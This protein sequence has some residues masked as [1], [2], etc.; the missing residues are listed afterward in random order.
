M[1]LEDPGETQPRKTRSGCLLT[2]LTFTE[3]PGGKIPVSTWSYAASFKTTATQRTVI[4]PMPQDRVLTP[5]TIRK[6]FAETARTTVL[7]E[8]YQQ[9]DHRGGYQLSKGLGRADAW[10]LAVRVPPG[11]KITGSLSAQA[12]TPDSPPPASVP[13][14]LLSLLPTQ[15][16][17]PHL[18]PVHCWQRLCAAE[19]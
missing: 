11:R 1:E 6:S 5:C 18:E 13:A 16:M 12:L 9:Q 15:R 14:R 7:S 4:L 8:L 19:R 2:R 3:V 17:S 10:R